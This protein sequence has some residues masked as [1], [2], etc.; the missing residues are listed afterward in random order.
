MINIY[1]GKNIC[2]DEDEKTGLHYVDLPGNE[3]IV[4]NPKKTYHDPFWNCNHL[5]SYKWAH[6]YIICGP[7]GTGKSYNIVEWAIKQKLKLKDNVKIYWFRLSEISINT[8]LANN[9]EKTIDPD[10]VRKYNLNIKRVTNKLYFDD[11]LFAEF[12]D[13]STFAKKTKGVQVY[14]KDYTGEYIVIL[15]EFKREASEK[16][17]FDVGKQFTG[18]LESILR[19]DTKR[20]KIFMLGNDADEASEIATA[21]DFI[22]YKPGLYKVHKKDLLVEWIQPND[23]YYISLD[24]TFQAAT[25]LQGDY[26]HNVTD[27][28]EFIVN[29]KLCKT[30]KYIIKFRRSQDHWFVIWND[31]IITAYHNEHGNVIA[32]RP[33]VGDMFQPPLRDA[34]KEQFFNNS[35]FYIAPSIYKKFVMEMQFFF[36]KQ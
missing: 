2:I 5:F 14:D 28:S 16:N 36:P 34:I 20:A 32:M 31:N 30:P 1:S 27:V 18:A 21:F 26:G 3:T 7:R 35:F 9:A 15:D 19:K 10:L 25:G 8:M 29:K 17:M 23:H 12:N 6:N 24:G 13:L 22:P 33:N 11:L 4:Y